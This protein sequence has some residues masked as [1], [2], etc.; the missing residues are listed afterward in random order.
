MTTGVT[1]V[2]GTAPPAL[3]RRLAVVALV[4]LAT[5]SAARFVSFSASTST[6]TIPATEAERISTLEATAERDPENARV[7]QQLGVAY[8]GRATGAA[9]P[10]SYS[11]STRAFDRADALAP[12]QAATSVGRGA[13]LL[14]LH[15]FERARELVEPISRR[16]PFN[17]DAL[18]VLVDA[19]VELGQYDVAR[20]ALQQLLDL[21]PGLPAYS[22]TSYLRELH[23]D[24]V[25]AERAMRQARTAGASDASDVAAITTFLGDLAL[26]NGDLAAAESA[27]RDALRLEPGHGGARFGSAQVLAAQGRPERA[28]RVLRDLTTEIPMLSAF[29]LLGELETDTGQPAAAARSFERFRSRIAQER[30]VGANT[31]L[32]I[33]V[34]EAEHGTSERSLVAARAAYATLPDNI[35]TADALAW[36]LVKTGDVRAARPFMARAL[37]TGSTE[38][39]MRYHSAVIAEAL[40]DVETARRDLAS[41]FSRT[42]PFSDS[43]RDAARGLAIRLGVPTPRAWSE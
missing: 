38:T 24:L 23:G 11:L 35:Y 18:T 33:A 7:W 14:S 27:Y 9:D 36:A 20:A 17:A 28:I 31:D 21:K 34:F 10:A 3:L 40:G 15:Q 4:A 12:G 41:V 37:R 19:N 2:G 13:L 1:A 22:R 43:Q 25:G 32:E 42:P 8:L 39:R 6:A 26:R 29:V 5:F 16:D 30:E